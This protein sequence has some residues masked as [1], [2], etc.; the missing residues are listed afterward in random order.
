MRGNCINNNKMHYALPL[1][2][3]FLCGYFQVRHGAGTGLREIL[4]SHGAGGGK[5]VGC[6]GEQ[7]HHLAICLLLFY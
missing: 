6:T 1:A 4:K 5:M 3:T 2:N 7:V